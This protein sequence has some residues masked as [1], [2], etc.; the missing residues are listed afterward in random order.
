M[1]TAI[2]NSAGLTKLI[3]LIK[4]NYTN[5]TDLAT[6]L[7]AKQGTLTFDST[8]TA[9]STNPVTSGGIQAAIAEAALSGQVDLSGYATVS[10]MNTALSAKQDTLTFDSA[11]TANSS[12]P[13]TSGGI[14]S[15]IE[16][17][18]QGA[19]YETVVDTVTLTPDDEYSD[20]WYL[21]NAIEYFTPDDSVY[22][23]T[24]DGTEYILSFAANLTY[25]YLGNADGL[26][27]YGTDGTPSF[28]LNFDTQRSTVQFGYIGSGSHTVK[29]ERKTLATVEDLSGKQD[30]LIFDS[31]PTQNSSNPVTS[32]GV[33]SAIANALGSVSSMEFKVCGTGEYNASTGVP[34]VA[35]PDGQHIY[36]VPNS[37]SSPNSYDEY[38]Y[39]N[40]SYEKIGTTDIDLSGYATV[41]AM[42]TAISA[43]ADTADLSAVATS[44]DYND[45]INTTLWR[46]PP[47]TWRTS[48]TRFLTRVNDNDYR[49]S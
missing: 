21:E 11:P 49:K 19:G 32:G 45:L 17:A 37:G 27:G 26:I 43:K 29:I 39:V 35:S 13:V 36:L 40:N 3:Q 38:V 48:G 7:A 5:N 24:V 22:R 28:I 46:S 18:V 20:W 10:A 25:R 30:V 8:P 9:G 44:G 12:N 16:T 34:T 41:S 6:A 15:A 33:Y 23:V 1:S 31:A 42:N 14:K 47:G 2:F 4:N